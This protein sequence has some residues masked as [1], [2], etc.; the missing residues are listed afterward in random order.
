MID[1][2]LDTNCMPNY[3]AV[4]IRLTGQITRK[5]KNASKSHESMS[6]SFVKYM[7]KQYVA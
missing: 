2:S 7:I 4:C 5:I 6:V 3:T 1:T